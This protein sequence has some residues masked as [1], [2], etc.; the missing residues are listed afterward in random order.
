MIRALAIAGVM[1]ALPLAPA[2]AQDA[3]FESARALADSLVALCA[4]PDEAGVDALWRAL[5]AAE[6]IPFRA[7][8]G[9]VFLYRGEAASVRF[10][11]D[12]NGWGGDPSAPG[13]AQRVGN[14][15]DL[16]LLEQTFP[17]DARIDYKVVLDD[18]TWVLDPANP[19][20]QWSGHGPNSELRMPGWAFPAETVRDESTP[21]GT[22]SD[23][24]VLESEHL[25]YAVAYRV[26]LPAG[27]DEHDAL[28][29]I[30]VTDGHEYAD[31][32]LGAMVAVLDNLIAAGR[33]AP[34][35]AV[36]VDPREVGAPEHNR[37][38]EQY[39]QNAAFL[40]FL[41]EEL[42]PA[43]DAAHGTDARAEARAVLGTSLG[44][45]FSTSAGLLRP[46]VFGRLGIQSPAY[47]VTE[48]PE[49]WIGPSLFEMV[50]AVEGIAPRIFLSTGT[51]HDGEAHTRRMRDLFEAKGWALRYREVPEGHSWGNWRALLD[52]FL[53][54]HFPGPNAP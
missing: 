28:P 39:V 51:I 46:D 6:Q 32:R 54:F 1:L 52:E 20:R 53:T 50:E 29:T 40:A 31:D 36:F 27:H 21:R 18:S 12:F 10:V 14:C 38:Q 22:L 37:R 17:P 19:H 34:V 4:G 15:P 11:G 8:S 35:L 5:L 26:Y 42:V 33:V 9:A 16:W 43:I 24:L 13:E 48:N 2:S 23:D 41:A 3:A 49:W 25:D 45:V 44:G 30:Y 7:D 47:W